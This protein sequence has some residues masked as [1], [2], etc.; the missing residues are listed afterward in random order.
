M[1]HAIRT[2]DDN[3]TAL[4]HSDRYF[5]ALF[6]FTV[7]EPFAQ[8]APACRIVV[9]DLRTRIYT[10]LVAANDI[11]LRS[12]QSKQ[13]IQSDFEIDFEIAVYQSGSI[14]DI[15][16]L[17]YMSKY[18]SAQYM[19]LAR[20]FNDKVDRLPTLLG[21]LH[22]RDLNITV[23]EQLRVVF[24]FVFRK[25]QGKLIVE[26]FF[27]S[28]GFLLGTVL[29]PTRGLFRSVYIIHV[30]MPFIAVFDVQNGVEH[31]VADTFEH[32][33]QINLA[34]DAACDRDS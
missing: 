30:H 25:H 9:L 27:H 10:G 8:A 33:L 14:V 17:I 18:I 7:T 24:I 32:P 13:V 23:F 34:I 31:S 11:V 6:A 12:H 29:A 1:I 21:V 15:F 3:A 2:R 22:P 19:R 26:A 28:D 16:K 20:R 4:K 5:F